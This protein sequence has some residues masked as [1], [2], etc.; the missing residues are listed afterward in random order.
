MRRGTLQR[1]AGRCCGQ[2]TLGRV[3]RWFVLVSLCCGGFVSRGCCSELAADG[4]RRGV[5]R[6]DSIDAISTFY[7]ASARQR[8][9]GAQENCRLRTLFYCSLGLSL[10]G[11][12]NGGLVV[13]HHAKPRSVVASVAVKLPKRQDTCCYTAARHA[14][15]GSSSVEMRCL[16]RKRARR[17]KPTPASTS[18]GHLADYK[19]ESA[20]EAAV[21]PFSVCPWLRALL[22]CQLCVAATAT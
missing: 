8:G 19:S 21:L 2:A 22:L 18:S 20:L 7:S 16:Q 15:Q 17:Q 14:T 5:W 6:L 12:S 1:G 9:G 13:G 11:W 10:A 3:G 4:D